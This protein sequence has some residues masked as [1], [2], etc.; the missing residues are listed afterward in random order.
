MFKA[1]NKNNRTTY[2]T[3]HVILVFLLLV[4]NIFYTHFSSVF[5]V[6]F[7]QVNVIW[8]GNLNLM[9]KSRKLRQGNDI[10][11]QISVNY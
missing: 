2:L 4:L 5:V 9:V 3:P 6:D 11:H 7:E 8:I 1:N 10:C